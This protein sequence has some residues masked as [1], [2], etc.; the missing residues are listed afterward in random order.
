MIDERYD[1]TQGDLDDGPPSCEYCEEPITFSR[2]G[3]YYE[4]RNT[5][6][7]VFPYNGEPFVIVLHDNGVTDLDCET[8][9]GKEV[10]GEVVGEYNGPIEVHP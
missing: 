5:D 4:G 10:I 9:Y 1:L 7:S 2:P 8:E 3:S 6:A